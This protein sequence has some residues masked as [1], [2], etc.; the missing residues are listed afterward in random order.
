MNRMNP[1][2]HLKSLGLALLTAA[3]FVSLLGQ[4]QPPG[5]AQVGQRPESPKDDPPPSK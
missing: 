5:G 1:T 4:A 3:P 2:N